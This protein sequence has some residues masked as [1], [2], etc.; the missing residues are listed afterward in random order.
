[1]IFEHFVTLCGNSLFAEE[2]KGD[3]D[4][5]YDYLQQLEV[6]YD[7]LPDLNDKAE[8]LR[9][10]SI[11]AILTGNFGNAYKHLDSL[12]KLLNQ[13]PPEWGLRYTNYRVLA[14]YTRRFPPM[15]RFYQERGWPLNIP[16]LGNIIG[17]IEI[18][19]SFTKNVNEH[20]PH[21]LPRDKALCHILNVISWA[22]TSTRRLT[23]QFHPLSPGGPNYKPDQSPAS[24][25]EISAKNI[26]A[27]RD[28]A[29][30]NG[31]DSMANYLNRLVVEFYIACASPKKEIMLID[32]YQRCEKL[33]DYAGM[34]N[35]K[36]LEGDDMLC[37]PF[38]SPLALNLVPFNSSAAAGDN[39]FWDPIEFDLGFDYTDTVKGLYESALDLFKASGSKRGQAAVLFRQGCCLHNLARLQRT[40]NKVYVDFLV[41]AE[42]KFQDAV[43]LFGRDE[44]NVQFVRAHQIL[45]AISKRNPQRVKKLSREI[46]DW[47]A[48]AKNEVL[49]HVIGL[50]MGRFAYQ[51]W[52]KYSNLDTAQQAWECVYEVSR[53]V[54]DMVPL[55]QSIV[56]RVSLHHEMFN[57]AAARLLIEEA[58]DNIEEVRDYLS[59]KILPAPQTP[60]GRADFQ[61][62]QTTKCLFLW[63]FGRL[64]GQVYMR[65]E[66]DTAPFFKW[67]ARLSDWVENDEDF[68][69]WRGMIEDYESP[70]AG[71]YKPAIAPPEHKKGSLWKKVMADEAAHIKY[72]AADSG[73]RRLL[74]EGDVLGAE[75]IFRRF[76]IENSN[77]GKVCTR[78]L[79]RVLA[80]DRIGD[81]AKAREIFDSISD[82]E[83]FDGNLEAY[84]QGIGV[85]SSL[86]TVGQN[87]LTFALFA[88][89]FDRAR[90]LVRMISDM[91]PTFFDSV[92]DNSI[93]YSLR[94]GQYA[95]I[96]KDTEP[97]L[98]FSKLLI[99]RQLIETRRRQTTDLDARVW[100]S[101]AGWS[102]EIY[103]NL[104]R[105]CLRAG[106]L[107]LPLDLLASSGDEH[108]AGASWVDHALLFVEM[109][110]AR[111]VLESLQTQAAKATGLSEAP[112]ATKLSEA[113]HKRR[114]LRSLLSLETLTADQEKE[115]AQLRD[116]IK[117]LEE[118]GTL[119]SATTFID[120]VNSSIDP[121]LLYQNIDEDTV[122]IETTFGIRGMIAFAATRD[123]IQET[124]QS[125]F[126]QVDMKRPVMRALQIMRKLTGYISDEEEKQKKLLNELCSEISEVLLVPFAEIIRT[127]LHII[128]SVSDPLTAFPFSIL[129]FDGK[130]LIMQAVVSQVPSLT[131]LYYLSQRKSTSASPTVSVLAKSPTEEPSGNTRGGNEV[132]LHMA[133]IEAVN[134]ARMFAT[135][136]IEASQMTRKDFQQHVEGGSLIMHIGTHGDINNQNP[137]L[138]SISIGHGQEFRVVDMSAI[139]SN[140]NLLVFAACLSGFGKATIG[141][142]VLGFSHVVLSTGCQA[143]IGSLWK[144][145]DFG[146]ML[147]MTLFYQYLK[148][149]PHRPVAEAMR[150]AQMGLLQLDM[151]KAGV[152]LDQLAENWSVDVSTGQSPA[153]FVPDAEFLLWA[154]K[155][156]LEQL[157]WSSPFYWA[158]FTLVGYGGFRFL[159]EM[160]V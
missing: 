36:L 37:A 155:M 142:E 152:L 77:E 81:R 126:C 151:D 156:I 127:K 102:G 13:L 101:H 113:V 120:T 26:L 109:Y 19:Q 117:E 96:M 84:Q 98:C 5:A 108:I 99:A 18:S 141:S 95:A 131:V 121:K 44:A 32:L 62:L 8:Y 148:A 65:A 79:Y 159:H 114:L 75:E 144:V 12:H 25:I 71:D 67:H 90:R 2:Y 63:T 106:N 134:I 130:P 22:P 91:N 146:S 59:D 55:L 58:F 43:V 110:R 49:A 27:R 30:A 85:R 140:V 116:D 83:L 45:L 17:P 7:T 60:L 133:G 157:D 118:D 143:Y 150:A 39:T 15:L 20:L 89:D 149:N 33:N 48:T 35:A 73:F 9:C 88:G 97:E 105:I 138:S 3:L 86:P 61:L 145:S 14:D 10:S 87:A 46:G 103:L 34:A 139:K 64:V 78:D 123:G 4:A 42:T 80:C 94:L 52:H 137:L 53:A 128:F 100:S 38:T 76:V 40:S 31:A 92:I 24:D 66:E 28:L 82:D 124:H 154:L 112:N 6:Q 51:E 74:G 29:Q 56:C 119:T 16:M 153:E 54:D 125:S 50:L 115:V 135:W 11:Y 129:P 68:R 72:A 93:D 57:S 107:G 147:I 158:P 69:E 1:M 21:G 132:N 122:V 104:A 23:Q 47:C 136:P 41:E 160:D 70:S 111:A